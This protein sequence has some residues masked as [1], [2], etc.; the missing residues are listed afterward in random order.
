MPA[1][2][3]MIHKKAIIPVPKHSMNNR[4]RLSDVVLPLQEPDDFMGLLVVSGF[5]FG[6]Q[7]DQLC[8]LGLHWSR[9]LVVVVDW[10]VSPGLHGTNDNVA[11]HKECVRYGCYY[12]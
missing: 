11:K 4:E 10:M 5:E 9:C 1:Q 7:V 6:Q 12:F 8:G 3:A 2:M